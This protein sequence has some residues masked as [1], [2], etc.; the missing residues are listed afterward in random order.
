MNNKIDLKIQNG[1]T[2]ET[3][4]L[5][6]E[7]I[8]TFK[9]T[10]LI[11]GVAMI[12]LILLFAIIYGT[13]FAVFYGFSDFTSTMTQLQTS[14]SSTTGLL[15]TVIVTTLTSGF[16]APVTAG[17]IHANH[18]AKNNQEIGINVFFDFY[19]SK[20][21][22]DIFISF[23]ILGLTTSIL[24]A[25]LVLINLEFLSYIVQSI[26]GLLTVFT[27]PLI[28]YGNQNFENAIIKSVQLFFKQPILIF[29]ALLLAVIGMLLGIFALCI[30][31]IFT[32]PYYYSMVYAIY[33]QAIGFEEKSVI[34]E[35]GQEE[36]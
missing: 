4:S 3:G 5:I 36:I 19:K 13:L 7:S 10:F 34:D 22:K 23:L 18:L 24:N 2:L 14:Q 29:V 25:A 1:Y 30:G 28:I 32:F 15:T 31:I 8:A 20:F 27:L 33:N 26:I 9:K 12:L 21:F 35:I 16:F 17:F 11:S 6:D